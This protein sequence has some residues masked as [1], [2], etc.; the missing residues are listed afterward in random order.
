MLTENQP[1][2]T[3]FRRSGLPMQQ[4]SDGG[5]IHV[6]RA[7]AIWL[8]ARKHAFVAVS[9]KKPWAL[10]QNLSVKRCSFSRASAAPKHEKG[11]K[12]H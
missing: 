1:M 5:V 10:N 8:T 2:L 12:G 11:T 9:T 3:F 7:L 6:R 4:R